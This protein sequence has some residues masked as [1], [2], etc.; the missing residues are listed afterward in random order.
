MLAVDLQ[1]RLGSLVLKNPVL[2]ASGT[3]GYGVEYAGYFDVS[4]LGGIVTKTITLEPREGN[5]MPRTA[6]TFAGMLN[7]IG[8][9]NVGADCFIKEKLLPLEPLDTA[10]M[11][12]IAG[13][14]P[15]EYEKVA[16]KVAAHERV[17]ALEVNISC[18]NVNKGG[19]AFGT[20]PEITR[21]VVRR[22]RETT[23]KP[24][25]VKLTPNV[26]DIT[27]IAQ[28][29]VEG[30]ADALSLINTV[31]GMAVDIETRRPLLARHVGGLSGPA[32]KPIALAKLYQTVR[33]VSVPLIGIG[34][35]M[36]WQDA[37]EFIIVGA[38]AVQAGTL[39]FVDPCGAVKII[40]GI[41]T[42]CDEKGIGDLSSIRGSMED[43]GA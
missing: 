12:N 13:S 19:L 32:I 29:A 1:V 41:K 39:H 37:L 42:Y 17:D 34:G 18:P 25:I 38:T 21:E 35:I 5:P 10:V 22:V 40:E 4:R 3:F 8:L 31:L 14:S 27:A 15:D 2:T 16:L 36:T 24:L 6:E 23:V 28:A 43:G 7:S 11:V 9:A 33:A 20:D 30:G 26:T